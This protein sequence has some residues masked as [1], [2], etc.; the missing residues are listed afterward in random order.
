MP[1][2]GILL[3]AGLI[4][5]GCLWAGCTRSIRPGD[6][7]SAASYQP[8]VGATVCG[9]CHPDVFR[10]QSASN[11]ARTL[12][13]AADPAA[14]RLAGASGLRDRGTGIEYGVVPRNGQ[15]YQ[16]FS[17]N[18]REIGAA[19][20]DYLLG[21]GHHGISPMT[22]DGTEWRYLALTYYA[23]KGWDFSPMHDSGDA[24]A[25]LQNAAGWPVSVGE[26]RKC[27]GCH[28]TRVEFAGSQLDAPQ[29]ELGVRC[30]GCHG[31]GR[32]HV[33]AA[34]QHSPDPAIT[35][36]RKW[37]VESYLAL[38]EQCHNE[39]STLDGTLFGIPKD[40]KSPALAKFQVYEMRQ[41][42]CFKQSQGAMRC[43]TCHDPHGNTEPS[44]AFY[45]GKCR[46]CHEPGTAGQVACPVNPTR[47]CVSCHMPKVEV[48][49]HTYF[50][51]H[52]IR[53]RSPFAPKRTPTREA[54]ALPSRSRTDPRAGP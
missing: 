9:E 27:F 18:G 13:P 30:E 39:N 49:K 52:W 36:P 23:A 11:H 37:S 12:L 8:Y 40:P 26:L 17:K 53:A 44:P 54:A 51:D 29:T 7:T 31:P 43:T 20:I 3:L 32:A 24:H 4:L 6:E 28:S 21:S 33:E 19:R 15:L 38:C 5:T 22:F 14:A 48:E 25:R 46:S 50:A 41:S 34:R 2:R 1:E 47:D 10:A 35:N 42:R 45:T 16:T